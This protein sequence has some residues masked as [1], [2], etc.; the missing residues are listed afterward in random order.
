LEHA[1]IIRQLVTTRRVQTNEV[2]RCTALVPAFEL[3]VRRLDHR[4]PLALVEIGS[5]AG[6]N[7]LW[8]KYGYYYGEAGYVRNH[9]SGVQLVCVPQGDIRPPLSPTFPPIAYRI[10]IDLFPVDVN[11]EEAV[12]WLRA[13]I[14]PEHTDRV[15]L[16]EQA[17][18]IAQLHQA[19]IIP[20]DA[21]DLLLDVLSNVPLGT[22]LCV[23]H[24]Y[25]LNQCSKATREKIIDILAIFAQDRDFFRLSL[26]WYSGQNQPH[27]E[28][29]SYRNGQ[30]QSELLAYCESHGRMIEWFQS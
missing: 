30:M 13:L 2:Q 19:K 7:L 26:E 24:S 17:V 6:L 20:G 23:Y 8:D 10:G 3:I 22:V 28:L 21:V 1:E 12:R 14:W 9:E 29:F 15:V 5:S 16:L 11:D 25:T 27:L 4:R 18:Q